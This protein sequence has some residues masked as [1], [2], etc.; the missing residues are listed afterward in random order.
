M[1][2]LTIRDGSN[3]FLITSGDNQVS[4]LREDGE[5]VR[6]F[7][8]AADFIQSGGITPDGKVVLSGSQDGVLRVWNGTNGE[9]IQSFGPPKTDSS[10][11]LAATSYQ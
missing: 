7:G 11:K 3:E 1:S 4:R 10:N 6:T 8:G 5:N 9:V 2:F